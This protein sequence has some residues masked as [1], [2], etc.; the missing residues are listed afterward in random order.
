M[1]SKQKS[2]PNH[3]HSKF[4][5]MDRDPTISIHCSRTN[6]VYFEPTKIIEFNTLDHMFA[7]YMNLKCSYFTT[8]SGHYH[9]THNHCTGFL[10]QHIHFFLLLQFTFHNQR[11]KYKFPFH[12]RCKT[13]KNKTDGA[14][15]VTLDLKAVQ[16]DQIPRNA[17]SALKTKS[18]QPHTVL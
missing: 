1:Y 11:S 6:R 4:V 17:R 9:G 2:T 15:M 13:D 14:I 10:Q 18:F 5:T 7:A 8:I 16:L 12:S 3:R